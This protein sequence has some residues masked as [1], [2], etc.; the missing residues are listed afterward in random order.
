ML[1][2]SATWVE[3]M[4]KTLADSQSD[5]KVPTLKHLA[6]R[7]SPEQIESAVSTAFG[8]ELEQLFRVPLRVELVRTMLEAIENGSESYVA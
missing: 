8:V 2:G 4:R 7:P 3:E 6:W 1:L 5:V